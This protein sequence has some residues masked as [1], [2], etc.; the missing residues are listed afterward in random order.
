MNNHNDLSVKNPIRRDYLA[1]AACFAMV[2]F[3]KTAREDFDLLFF[4]PPSQCDTISL[5]SSNV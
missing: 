3:S 4:I 5:T 2:S 1:P